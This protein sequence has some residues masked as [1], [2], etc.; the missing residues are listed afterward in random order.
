[1]IHTLSWNCR[2]LGSAHAV[3]AFRRIVITEH[4]QIV[5]LT[6]TKLKSFEFDNVKRKTHFDNAFVV[7]CEGR[8]GEEKEAWL[9]CGNHPWT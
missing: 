6:E 9:S 8:E 5:F 2:G 3:N 7:S 1:M 4:P